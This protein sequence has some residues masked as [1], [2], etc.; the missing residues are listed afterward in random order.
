MTTTLFLSD[1]EVAD[2][3]SV[4]RATVWRWTRSGNFPDPIKLSEGCTRWRSTDLD[5]WLVDK[6]IEE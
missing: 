2:K 6:G 3:F 1:K 4:S 5:Q